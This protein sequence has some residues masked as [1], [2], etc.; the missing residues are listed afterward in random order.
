M[1]ERLTFD[2]KWALEITSERA[3]AVSSV[4]LYGRTYRS[5][6]RRGLLAETN[7]ANGPHW[8]ITEAGRNALRQADQE[9]SP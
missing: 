9:K 8:E 1:G 4:S 3:V 5:L 2:Q 7:F 6:L